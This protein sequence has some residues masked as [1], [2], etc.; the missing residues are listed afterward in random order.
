MRNLLCMPQ[1]ELK[2]TSENK[3]AMQ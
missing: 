3:E 1:G 2:K